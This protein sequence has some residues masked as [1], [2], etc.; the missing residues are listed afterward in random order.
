MVYAIFIRI[1]V[2]TNGVIWWYKMA[3]KL[4]EGRMMRGM[5]IS[6]ANHIVENKDGSFTVPSQSNKDLIYE[7]RIIESIW[8]CSCPDFEN[9]AN[10]IEACK[11]IHAVKFWIASNTYIQNKPKPKIFADDAVQCD[12]CGS[13]RVIRFGSRG[14]KQTYRCNDCQHRFTPSLIRKA[15]YSPEMITLTLDLYFSGMSYNKIARTLN[16]NFSMN[17]GAASVYRWAKRFVPMISKYV[18][19]L[20]PQLSDTW[21]AD[22]LFVKMKGGIKIQKSKGM[23]YLWNVMD[24]KTR[25]LLASKLSERRDMDG[26]L[27]ALS[28]AVQNAH[29]QKPLTLHT[30]ALRS[31]AEALPYAFGSRSGAPDHIAKCGIVKP[32]A[33]NNRIE[34]LNGTLRERVK[35]QRGW[36]TM[37]T[38]LAEGARI[39]YNFIKPH[40]ALNGQTP[41]QKAG[42]DRETWMSLLKKSLEVSY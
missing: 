20:A 31:Y 22:E 25:F 27:N 11:H 17:L 18:N 24:K 39:N 40:M 8:V 30:D 12:R 15:K 42:L 38:Q 13:I 10:E 19:N 23:A 9:R 3:T 26:A 1:L 4:D 5:E 37:K 21:A 34:R 36:K 28:E 33:N 2:Y 7:I 35:V 32:H 16:D 14:N 6:Q 41:A 29:D